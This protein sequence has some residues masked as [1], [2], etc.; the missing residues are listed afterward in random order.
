[1]NIFAIDSKLVKSSEFKGVNALAD[2]LSS[3]PS[4]SNVISST[5]IGQ[6]AR[7]LAREPDRFAAA[8]LNGYTTPGKTVVVCVSS[9]R[10]KTKT[11][12]AIGQYLRKKVRRQ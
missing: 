6:W 8:A 12:T 5:N 7:A 10:N 2:S 9:E 4:S 3:M 11:G 1:M